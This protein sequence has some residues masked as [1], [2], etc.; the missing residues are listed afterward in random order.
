[1][2]QERQPVIMV[3]DD[4]PANLKIIG[5]IIKELGVKIVFA[6]SG[7]QVFHYIK[8]GL[9]DLI[10]LDIMM[11]KMDGYA[12]CQL[13]K[14][15]PRTRDI[16]I[17]F[18]T[19]L[20]DV[21]D[22]TKGLDMGAVDFITKPTKPAIVRARVRTQLRLKRKT[23][24]LE[25]LAFIDGL[26]E[27]LNRRRF[28]EVLNSEWHRAIREVTTLSLIMIDIDCFKN[29]NDHYGHTAGDDCLR[30]VAQTLK[31]AI[32]RPGDN[33]AR[34]GGEEFAAI[35]PSTDL[36]SALAIA[37]TMRHHVESLKISH[38]HNNA[39]DFVT[40]SAGVA[41]A[42]PQQSNDSS[43]LIEQADQNLYRAKEKG[44]NQVIGTS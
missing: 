44:R 16:P 19:A 41:S 29:Y 20:G 24:L 23:D 28:D 25:R 7:E 40:I 8:K 32:K 42:S 22:E 34:Y 15:E 43:T 5:A 35:L 30:Q 38:K 12:V 33:I 31:G 26:T 36:T 3:V 21:E 11:P 6:Q 1:M 10:L 39:A 2:N 17:I 37:E 13:L 4:N 27:I 14:R 18:L 9:P